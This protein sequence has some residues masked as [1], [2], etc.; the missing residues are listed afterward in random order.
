[1]R[2]TRVVDVNPLQKLHDCGQS[3][4]LD[5]LARRF[6]ADGSLKR[7]VDEDGLSGITSNPTIFRKAITSGTDYDQSIN[8]VLAQ[9][10]CDAMELYERVAVEDIRSAADVLLPLYSSLGGADG[11]VSLEVSPYLAL[12]TNATIVEARRLWKEV[13]RPNIMIK[14]PGTQAGLP[15]IR[16]LLAEGINVNITLLFGRQV[17]RQVAEAWL[18]ALE[19]FT[20]AGGDPRRLASVASFFVSRIDTAVDKLIEQKIKE[21]AGR[22]SRISELRGKIAIANAKLAYQDYRQLFS[23]PALAASGRTR[24]ACAETLV[25]KH[26]YEESRLSRCALYRGVDRPRHGQHDAAGNHRGI[27]RSWQS[28]ADA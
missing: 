1:M 27:P 2:A 12:D 14:V 7:L 17:Y 24:R 11:F 10:D 4:W 23:G 18:A 26:E 13:A 6:I 28:G 8:S 25:G 20:A 9:S 16:Q 21:D 15:A 22:P 19:Q 5:F 3:F